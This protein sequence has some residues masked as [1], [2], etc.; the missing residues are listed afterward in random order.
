MTSKRRKWIVLAGGLIAGL[1]LLVWLISEREPE[2]EGRKLREWISA[3]RRQH[4]NELGTSGGAAEAIRKIGPAGI[5]WLLSWADREPSSRRFFQWLAYHLPDAITPA[6]FKYWCRYS[7]PDSDRLADEAC[8]AFFA[9]GT[10]GVS[11]IP[12]LTSRLYRPNR[13]YTVGRSA[14]MLCH[15]G[16]PATS[17]LIHQLETTN[18]PSRRRVIAVLVSH[19]PANLDTEKLIPP[20]IRCLDDPDT[21]IVDSANLVLGRW[22]ADIGASRELVVSALKAP[23]QHGG[24]ASWALDQYRRGARQSAVAPTELAL[25]DEA[26]DNSFNNASTNTSPAGLTNAP[27]L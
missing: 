1:A 16:R 4:G 15:I 5:P 17:V 27:R 22:A 13:P 18:A 14:Q 19:S 8:A 26:M 9:L 10:N 2:Y 6:K 11:A 24:Y 3:Y 21:E 20:I 7:I 25:P 12:E 23:R